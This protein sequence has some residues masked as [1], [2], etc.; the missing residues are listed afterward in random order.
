MSRRRG[1][2]L[3]EVLVATVLLAVGVTG[4]LASL[5]AAGRLRETARGREAV[6]AAMRERLSW[7]EAVAC[8]P[9]T[10]SGSLTRS[11]GVRLRW[12]V[13]PL[14]TDSLHGGGRRAAALVAERGTAQRAQRLEL[15]TA[16][17]CT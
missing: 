16:R 9:E 1:V 11:D 14:E 5:A 12:T 10:A 15:H 8:R 13:A 2:S 4:T 7:F 6:A 3:V 17:P